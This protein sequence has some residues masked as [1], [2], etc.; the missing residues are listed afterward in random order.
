MSEEEF[1]IVM[2]PYCKA[3]SKIYLKS[4]KQKWLEEDFY[5]E[6]MV[7]SLNAFRTFD[8]GKGCK[9]ENYA[10]GLIKWG[11]CRLIYR[12]VNSRFSGVKHLQTAYGKRLANK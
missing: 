10:V 7:L 12:E 11:F 8:P 2:A 5:Q 3:Y 9:M 1:L 6:A 4:F